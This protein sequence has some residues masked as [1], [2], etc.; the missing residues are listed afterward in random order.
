MTDACVH[1]GARRPG[2]LPALL[3]LAPLLMGAVAALVLFATR[4]KVAGPWAL[5]GVTVM[6]AAFLA[7]LAFFA[8]SV[9]RGSTC[10]NCGQSRDG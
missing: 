1:C 10:S 3:P 8:R 7:Y 2:P 4:G 5:A 6:F 9:L